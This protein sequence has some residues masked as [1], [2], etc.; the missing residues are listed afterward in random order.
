MLAFWIFYS[1]YCFVHLL[2]SFLEKEKLRKI[3]KVLI[4]PLLILGLFLYNVEN[5][6]IYLGLFSGW[7]GDMFLLN[8]KQKRY[9]V[10][11]T[12]CFVFGHIAYILAVIR[13][14]I[15]NH[16]VTD[17]LIHYLFVIL[18]IAIILLLFAYFKMKKKLGKLAYLGSTYFTIIIGG[19]VL[20]FLLQKPLLS[21]GFGFFIISDILI[22]TFRFSK[23][24]KRSHFYIMITYLLAQ[25]LIALSFIL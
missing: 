15:I 3:T 9:F 18:I 20:S 12:L 22:S 5:Y 8:N 13:L 2:F 4:M 11:G 7:I 1:T 16:G 10:I 17:Q 6:L 21:L 24:V 23:K 19:F 25:T 14:Y